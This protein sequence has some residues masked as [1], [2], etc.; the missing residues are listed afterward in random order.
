[1]TPTRPRTLALFLATLLIAPACGI[2]PGASPRESPSPSFAP[3]ASATTPVLPTTAPQ[4]DTPATASPAATDDVGAADEPPAGRLAAGDQTVTGW[5]GTYC[6]AG[7]CADAFRIPP[8]STL[9]EIA[10]AGPQSELTFG[11]AGDTGFIEWVAA[12][13]PGSMADLAPLAQGGES[14]DP[15][16]AATVP[17]QIA[18]TTFTSPL[19]GDWVIYVVIRTAAGEAHYAWHLVVR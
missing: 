3:T 8:L 16:S 6:W 11:L 4:T 10:V 14:Y 13:G 2:A 5:L 7:T 17:P 15:D 18:E 12:Y 1:M 19:S 9:P